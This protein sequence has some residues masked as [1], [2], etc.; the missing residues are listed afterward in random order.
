MSRRKP[1]SGGLA[2][3]SPVPARQA[4]LSRFFQS[5]GS[6]KSTSSPT[7]ATDQVDRD[8]AAPPAST[9][10]PQLPPLVATEIDRS[11]KRPLENDGPVKKKVKK[12]QQKE[13]GSDLGMSGNSEPKKCLRTRSV[14][15][16]LEKLKEFCCDSALPQSRVQTESVQER[17]AVLPK[18]TDFDDI[19]LLRAKNAVSSEDSKCQIK[20]K[21]TTLFDVSQF[22]SSNTSHENL[23]KTASK[24]ANKRSKSIYTPLELQYIEMK[25]QHKDAVLCVECGYKY[26]FFGEDAEVGVVKQTET[27]ALKA[28]GD[29]RSS[30]FSRKLTAL[31]TKSTLIGEDVNPLI[32]L[33]DAVNVDEIMTDTS[34]SYLLCISENKENVRDKKKGNVFIGIVGVQPATGEV[35]FDSFQDSASRSELETRMSNLQPVELLLPSALSE[36]TEMLIHRATSVSVQDD[37]I[38]VERM[39]NIYFEY[40]HAFQAVTEFYAKDTVDIKGSQIISGIVNLEK[41]VICSLAAIIKY[42]KEFNLEKMLSKPENFKQLSSKMEFMTI[43]GTTLRNLEILQNQTDMKTKGSLLWVLDHTKTSFGRRKLKKWVT[44]PLLKLREIN[45]RLDAV[46]EVLHSESS[47][48]GQIE[49]HLRKLPDIERGLCSIYHKKCSTQEFF[50]IVKTLYHLKSEFQAIVP[51]VNSHVQSDLLRTVILEI[52]ELLSPVEHYLKILNEQ[53]AKVGDKT[54]LFKDLSDFPLIKKRKDEIQ[55]VSDKIRMHLQEIRKILKNPSAQ[56]V[57]V[58]GQEFM[59]EIKN[60]AV[61]CIPTDWVKVGSTKAVSR[62]HSPFVVENYRHL[63][64]LREQ[65]V[66]DC[67]A[68]W[69]DFLEK[70]SEHYHYLCKAVHHLATVD[71]IF[72]LAKVAK[73][74]DYCRPTVQ[75]ERKII[76]KNGRHPVIDVLLGEQ[77]QYVPNSTDLSE[78]SERVMIITGP[79]MGGKSSYIKQVALITIMAQIG[80]YVP[81]EEAT[82]GIVDGIFT[83]MGAA[84]NI[85]KGR[86]TF[87]EELT[88][89]AEIIRKATSQSLVILDELGR[90]TSTH[91]GIAI[92]YATLEYF[93]R[94]VKSLTLFVTHYPPV[95]ELEKNYSHQV[96][97]YHMGFLVSEDESKLDPGEEQVP[98]FVTFLYQITRGIA[99]RSYGLNVAKLADVP[100][101]ILKKAAHKSKELEGLINTKRKRLKYFAKLWTMHNAQDLQKW[102]EEF[103][104]EETQTSLPH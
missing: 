38:R 62:F 9:F 47:V 97:N 28:I 31:Y 46:S 72:S 74:G 8:A 69:L 95:C 76:I 61:S 64:Q 87:M 54:E 45:A 18:C 7:G 56:Y 101:E 92:A 26:R 89:T 88:D 33:D 80:S 53:A 63:N 40:S 16:S 43:N 58:S 21:D 27:A 104:M 15:K 32:K 96:G 99:A 103:E 79:N 29:N 77:D 24:P 23:Q 19:S 84:D 35:V 71:C 57:T 37:R 67:S 10:P 55:G 100:G 90:G 39:D 94:D 3:S 73:Q 59:I 81:A 83:R 1:A 51:A 42:L 25:Q 20:Q 48:F 102:T 91:D 82:I 44:Q 66:L 2:A 13:G 75:E 78:D 14:L 11:K 17:F 4:V 36:Q 34:T 68:E 49:N 22:G 12:A 65:L 52:P 30:L 86:S 5:T 93:I 98:D 50:L 41:P 60:S 70:F 85:Y 6:L